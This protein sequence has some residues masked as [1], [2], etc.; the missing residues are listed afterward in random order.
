MNLRISSFAQALLI[1]LAVAF[2][3]VLGAQPVINAT[4]GKVG[5]LYSYKVNSS[6]SGTVVYSATGLPPGLG[7]SSS[8]GTITGTPTTSGN[9]TGSVSITDSGGFVN[10]AT[11]IIQVTAAEGTPSISSA[12]SASGTV[13][14]TFG[15][16]T[17]AA[18]VPSGANP[19]TSFNVGSL[20]PG[21]SVGGTSLAPVISG[22]PTASGT[23]AVSLSAN[24]ATGTGAA[25]TLTITIAPALSA[26]VISGSA[27]EIVAINGSF[28][29][30]IA[31]SNSP[32]SY[33]ASGLPV[34]LSL[35]TATGQISG[36][37]SVPGVYAITLRAYNASGAGAPF[38]LTI[39]VGAL[40]VVTSPAVASVNAGMPFSYTI[41]ASN[42]P[43]S[44]N[45]G[46]LPAGLTANTS[47]GAITGTP[48]SPGTSNV[49]ISANNATGTGPAVQLAITVGSA[50]AIT[51][52]L[53]ATG[54]V[55]VA[56]TYTLSASN[57]PTG[58]TVGTL[59]AGL[60]YNVAGG[61]ITGTPTTAG[62]T[63]VPVSASNATGSGPSASLV[64]TIA[65][66]PAGGGGGG[67]GGGAGG[68]GA[69][70]VALPSIL[71]QPVSLTVT[72]GAGAA[73]SVSVS[74]SGLNFQWF[75]D[76]R[77]I[78]GAQSATYSI[79]ATSTA[80]A[81][82]YVVFVTN[83]AGGVLSS[84]AVL[85]VNAAPPAAPVISVQ[86]VAVT[87]VIGGSA[88][89]SVA[90]SGS[91]PFTYQWRRD[92]APIGGATAATLSVG[93]L[94]A[95]SAGRYSVLVS[96][97]GGSVTSD[98]AAL[99]IVEPSVVGTYFGSFS[100]GGGSFGLIVRPD[101]SA[102]FLGFIPSSRQVLLGSDLRISASGTFSFSQRSGAA[103]GLVDSRS[104]AATDAE[105][106]VSGSIG[107]DGAISG[108]VPALNLSFSAASGASSGPTS[109]VAGFYRTSVAGGT[110]IGYALLGP[111]GDALVV[112][113]IAGAVDGGRGTVSAE[114]RVNL[115]T[116]ANVT[117]TGSVA[118][119][120]ASLSAGSVVFAGTTDPR[121]QRLLNVSTRSLT[122]TA[123]DTLIGGFVV[124]GTESKTVLIRG[125]GPTL[126]GLGVAGALSAVRLEVFREQT[127]IAVGTDWGASANNP[128]EVAAVAARVGA[129]ALQPNSRDA[130]LVLNLAPGAYSAVV[131]GQSG[132]FGV[133]LL[134]VYDATNGPIPLSQ[135]VV[136]IAS[137]ATAGAGEDVLIAGFYVGGSVPKR[138]LIRGIGPALAQFGVA[139]ALAR[140][141]L[142]IASGATVLAQNS[143][144]AS[145][146]DATAIVAAAPQV[147]AFALPANAADAAILI[148]LAPGAYTAQVSGVGGTTGVALVEVY[149]VP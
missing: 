122:G 3:A 18:T 116:A 56:L 134:E 39:T 114:G 80:S 76:S 124:S 135:R 74:G 87:G 42:N 7:I 37:A 137:R 112:N 43:T 9:Y 2:P 70:A 85:T 145:S 67:A 136:N 38:T 53:A 117:V 4:A 94:T 17:V 40:P 5:V 121:N 148:N 106:V 13:G 149:E 52:S 120:V 64:F 28:L 111:A 142:S 20:P 50:P 138:V 129:F 93:S 119:G 77:L 102:V 144:L 34:G 100:G 103:G 46:N 118:Q 62:T 143:G 41:A 29:Y 22:T 141:Q 140:P 146:A 99:T 69:P 110:G 32:T 73:F 89:F 81:G 109:S 57:S 19:V 96:N 11:I 33:E 98:A 25:V 30:T 97:A 16:Y 130:A 44:Y 90:V 55:G 58:Y 127:S 68:G 27:A 82:A 88:S 1:A 59:P 95:A 61:T 83:S 139:G 78:E 60:I 79:A 105:I 75:K 132:A 147:G 48:A 133:A 71:A 35:N 45:V 101:R 86:P 128:T 51:S 108:S 12:T 26:P 123:T 49:V 72:E 66:A 126:S 10:S 14:S 8:Q 91:G 113:V 36:T 65:A 92:G 23:Y 21:L 115:T 15:A 107:P 54:T 84:S 104:V 24:S 31:A 125:I 63:S 47:T 131:T 6:A